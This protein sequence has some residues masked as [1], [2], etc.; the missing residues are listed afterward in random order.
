MPRSDKFQKLIE[1][2]RK[3]NPKLAE[4]LEKYDDPV[5]E[6]A[7]M[8][9]E[10]DMIRRMEAAGLDFEKFLTAVEIYRSMKHLFLEEIKEELTMVYLTFNEIHTNIWNVIASSVSEDKVSSAKA[11]MYEE[12]AETIRDFRERLKMVGTFFS[13]LPVKV[14]EEKKEKKKVEEVVAATTK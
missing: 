3:F 7:R 11:R 8:I 9:A 14:E 12:V 2:I 6:V 4:E 13:P 1:E 5:G 10:Y